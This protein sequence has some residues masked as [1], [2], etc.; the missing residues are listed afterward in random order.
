[1]VHRVGGLRFHHRVGH[2]DA[3]TD[4]SSIV[5][6][7]P[8]LGLFLLMILGTLG[9]PFPEDATLV[10]G[11]LLVSQGVVGPVPGF[12]VLYPSMLMG[13]FLLYSIGKKYGR[14]LVEHP[15]FRKILSAERLDMLETKFRRKGVWVVMAGRQFLGLRAQIFLVAGVMRIP[16]LKFALSDAVSALLT[17]GIWG[18]VGY[19]G[20]TSVQALRE[21]ISSIEHAILL[22][23]IILIGIAGAIHY[24]RAYGARKGG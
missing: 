19:Q 1:M 4:L 18:W 24:M 23:A 7:F 11:G 22:G 9:L 14:Q 2:P 12:L 17:M 20:G 21:G 10:L 3:M 5:E 15:R 13:D 8:Y 6:Q 16:A